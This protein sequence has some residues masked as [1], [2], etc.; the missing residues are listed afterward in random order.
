MALTGK[1][2]SAADAVTHGLVNRLAAPGQV[3]EAALELARTITPNAPAAVEATRRL[4]HESLELRE[5][6]F[7]P[8]QAPVIDQVFGSDDAREGAQAFAEKRAPR[9][10]GR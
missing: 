2:I 10:T 8:A 9:W 4:I 5:D 7:W 1:P 3:L 6:E